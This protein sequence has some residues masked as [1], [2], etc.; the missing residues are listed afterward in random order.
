MIICKKWLPKIKN[1]LKKVLEYWE[2]KA[3]SENILLSAL[4]EGATFFPTHT[5]ALAALSPSTP[6]F[7]SP[8]FY[9]GIK[10]SGYRHPEKFF[11]FFEEISK[12]LNT[13]HC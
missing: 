12:L 10:R 8:T 11:G 9:N 2:A 4:W 7:Y 5:C 13:L 3:Q 6:F 1:Y